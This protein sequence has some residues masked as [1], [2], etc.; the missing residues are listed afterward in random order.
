[1]QRVDDQHLA[2]H[3][4]IPVR[5]GVGAELEL[6]PRHR[7]EV[8]VHHPLRQ[9]RVL[10]QRSPQFFWRVRKYSFDHKRTRSGGHCFTSPATRSRFSRTRGQPKLIA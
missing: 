2:I 1:M 5:H 6:P 9:Q 7:L 4:A 10:G 8:V 3:N